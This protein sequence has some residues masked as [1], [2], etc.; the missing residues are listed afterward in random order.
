MHVALQMN[1][2]SDDNLK[3]AKQ[4][5]VDHVVTG[6]PKEL[7]SP[8][9]GFWLA[10]DLKALRERIEA[11]GISGEVMALP[12][13]SSDITRAENP[14]IMLGTADRDREIDQICECIRAA[15]AA[16]IPC[17]KYNLTIMGVITTGRTTG[18]GGVSYRAFDYEAVK[19]E[20]L[21]E[22][23][24]VDAEAMW[25][26][27][28]Y[29]V[30]RVIPVAEEYKVRMACHQHDPAVPHDVGVRGVNRVLGSVD[31]VKK[32]IDLIDSPYHGLNFCQGTCSEMLNDPGSEIFDVIRYFGQRE[33]IFMV[34]FR[35]IRGGFLK[36]EEVYID[37][38]DVDMWEAMKVYKEIGYGGV[39]CP[40]HVP[41]SEQDS[42]W[43]HRQRAFTAGY[44][45]ALIKAVN[46]P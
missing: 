14:N 5:G 4:I 43:G 24:R 40:D 42:G 2:L 9:R 25:E 1:D 45:K 10:D 35:N 34:H 28:N 38:G 21:T 41:K 13:S 17:L 23:G 11:H 18:R 22:A 27:I 31:G 20:P 29:F 46:N 32:F 7:I 16:G 26:R 30:Q 3:F 39:F 37:E 19:D 8:E 15:A 6:T 33:K 44:I 36:F 12:L